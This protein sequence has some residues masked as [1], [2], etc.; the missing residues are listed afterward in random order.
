MIIIANTQGNMKSMARTYEKG[1]RIF[2]APVK[3]AKLSPRN[4]ALEPY[5]GRPGT[6]IDVYWIYMGAGLRNFHIYKVR[7]DNEDKEIVL[8]DDEIKASL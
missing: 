5:I 6:V 7:I 2:V 1:Q 8:H 3:N 4:S